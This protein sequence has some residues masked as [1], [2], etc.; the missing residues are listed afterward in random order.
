MILFYERTSL[1]WNNLKKNIIDDNIKCI[2]LDFDMYADKEVN[3]KENTIFYYSY[4]EAD[5]YIYEGM[6][7]P[8]LEGGL[9]SIESEVLEHIG[10]ATE[11]ALAVFDSSDV[12]E[13][14]TGFFLELATKHNYHLH[15]IYLGEWEGV[16]ILPKALLRMIKNVNQYRSVCFVNRYGFINYENSI[17]E[18]IAQVQS[19]EELI[20]DDIKNIL[21]KAEKIEQQS[22]L[23]EVYLYDFQKEEYLLVVLSEDEITKFDRERYGIYEFVFPNQGKKVCSMLKNLRQQYAKKHYEKLYEEPCGFSGECRGTCAACEK[24]AINLWREHQKHKEYDGVDIY[25]PVRGIERLRIDT[26]GKGIRT[27]IAMN[28]CVLKC[29]YCINKRH[30]NVFPF[31]KKTSTEQLGRMIEKDAVY[32]EMSGGGVTFG[33]GEPLL[34]PDFIKEFHRRYPEWRIDIQTSLNVSY[35]NINGLLSIID[36]WHIDIKDMNPIIYEAYTGCSNEMVIKNL[37][38]LC[39]K[40]SQ[41]KINVRVPYISGYN[42]DKDVENSIA[43]LKKMGIEN[44]EEFEYIV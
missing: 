28:D 26:D 11:I 44:I 19:Y 7:M 29:Q 1:G 38:V 27:L 10:E 20:S 42:L 41:D 31:Y 6:M 43:I 22:A 34:Y 33:G 36:G 21:L 18:C 25:A 17:H 4:E 16:E 8:F 35:Y 24:T 30:I 37:K 32:F 9:Y 2:A 15:L 23:N 3:D 12:A 39:K 40:I 13:A 5:S 14:L